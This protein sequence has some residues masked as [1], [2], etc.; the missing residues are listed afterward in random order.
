VDVHEVLDPW[1]ETM[2]HAHGPGQVVLS[3]DADDGVSGGE[4]EEDARRIIA[5]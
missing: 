4:R 2:V 1:G 3:R 5:V